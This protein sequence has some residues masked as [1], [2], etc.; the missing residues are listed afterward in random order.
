VGDTPAIPAEAEIVVVSVGR[1]KVEV[2][3]AVRE[4]TGLGLRQTVDLVDRAPFTVRVPAGS[5]NDVSRW[6]VTS[7]AII[8]I[9]RV[10]P[11][12][13]PNRDRFDDLERLGRLHRDGVLSDDEFAAAKK[14][15]L[16]T[17]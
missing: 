15:V 16:D 14:R 12:A 2:I 17:I 11:P 3:E 10:A 4:L 9:G 7:G 6:L 1:R 13:P 5:V 8:E